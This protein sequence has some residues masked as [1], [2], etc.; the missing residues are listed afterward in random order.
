MDRS[1]HSRVGPQ[2]REYPEGDFVG[3]RSIPRIIIQMDAV[4][5]DFVWPRDMPTM[6]NYDPRD[7]DLIA[8]ALNQIADVQQSEGAEHDRNAWVWAVGKMI[9]DAFQ[10]GPALAEERIQHFELHPPH[11]YIVQYR[12]RYLESLRLPAIE[13]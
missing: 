5:F 8:I 1:R 7:C 13:R 10:L 2:T 12:T 4:T 11:Q 3:K 6:P 9:S